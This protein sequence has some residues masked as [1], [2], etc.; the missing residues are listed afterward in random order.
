MLPHKNSQEAQE[1]L[2]S[3]V[4]RHLRKSWRLLHQANTGTYESHITA[5]Q[6]LSKLQLT[7]HEFRQLAQAADYKTA[8]GLARTAG[9]DLRFFLPPPSVPEECRNKELIQLFRDILVKLPAD[10]EQVHECI[11]YF[12]STALDNY[13]HSYE[14]EVFDSDISYE[15]HRESHHIHS[16][17]RPR[18]SQV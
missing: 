14:E 15:F 4:P 9:V 18:I 6:E 7:D 8:V 11:K 10:S 5:V 3:Y 1:E 13:L 12:T 17:P 2:K 16:I